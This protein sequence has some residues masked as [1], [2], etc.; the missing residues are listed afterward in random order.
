MLKFNTVHLST[1]TCSLAKRVQ[2]SL[3]KP[4]K[5]KKGIVLTCKDDQ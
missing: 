2:F 5:N 1:W 3:L 4:P